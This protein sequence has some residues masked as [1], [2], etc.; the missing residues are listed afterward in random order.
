MRLLIKHSK[1]QNYELLRN[2][3]LE[4]NHL[5]LAT[6]DRFKNDKNSEKLA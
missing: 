6:F 3:L 4:K 5:L 1:Q 2:L